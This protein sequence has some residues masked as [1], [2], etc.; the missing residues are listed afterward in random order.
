MA[1]HGGDATMATVAIGDGD[2]WEAFV[3]TCAHD[4]VSGAALQVQPAT[5]R[6]QLCDRRFAHATLCTTAAT[7]HMLCLVAIPC[8]R[9]FSIA[10]LLVCSA[11]Q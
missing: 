5:C 3:I 9:A 4:V 11:T 8:A 1:L 10:Q 6:M 2:Y 7:I